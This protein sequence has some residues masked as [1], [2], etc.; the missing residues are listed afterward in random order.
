[1]LLRL[2]KVEA[3]RAL[4]AGR[5]SA[6]GRPAY[7]RRMPMVRKPPAPADLLNSEMHNLKPMPPVCVILAQRL[8]AQ[9]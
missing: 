7:T 6:P 5:P 4:A 8:L 2:P 9:Y 3:S 1:M